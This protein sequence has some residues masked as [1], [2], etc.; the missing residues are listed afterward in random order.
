MK[1]DVFWKT[2]ELIYMQKVLSNIELRQYLDCV[3]QEA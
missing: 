2:V 1:V 3:Y